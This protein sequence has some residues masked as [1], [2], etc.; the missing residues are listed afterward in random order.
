MIA[1]RNGKTAGSDQRLWAG[2]PEAAKAMT[3]CRLAVCCDTTRDRA[4]ALARTVPS[5]QAETDWRQMVTRPEIDL[6]LVATTHDMLAP[7]ACE[8]ASAGK[9]VLIEKP[10]ARRA[11]ELD[12]AIGRPQPAARLAA[13]EAAL[14]GVEQVY[15]ECAN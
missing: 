14:R 15:Q 10:G 1:E 11:A 9:H 7:I 8:A 12:S 5:A 6:V 4:E 3:G 2:R 13:A